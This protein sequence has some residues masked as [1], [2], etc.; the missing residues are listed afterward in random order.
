MRSPAFNV[1]INHKYDVSATIDTGATGSM[2]QLNIV[3]MAHLTVYPTKHS[4]EQADGLSN[5]NVV[6]EVHTFITLDDDLVL[7]ISAVVVTELKEDILIGTLFL[8]QN[9]MVLDFG[10]DSIRVKGRDI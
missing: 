2:I 10:T 3:E 5:L 9:K 1:K 8:K 7:P 6:G 4:A